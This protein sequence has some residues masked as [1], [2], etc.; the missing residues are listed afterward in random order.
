MVD[1]ESGF[2]ITPSTPA[3][4]VAEVARAITAFATDRGLLRRKGEVA[5]DRVRDLFSWEAKADQIT[6]AYTSVLQ[7]VTV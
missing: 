4:A 5:R 1:N 6:L 3:A 7:P 2:K